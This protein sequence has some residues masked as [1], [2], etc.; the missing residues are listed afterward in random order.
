GD[1]LL[2]LMKDVPLAI[3]LDA[4]AQMYANG[5]AVTDFQ[6]PYSLK[7]LSG[8]SLSNSISYYFYAFLYERGEVGGVEDAFLYFNDLGGKPV[9]LLAGQFQVSDPMFKRE[10]RLEFEDYAVYRARMGDVPSDLT[11]DRGVLATA[12]L[13][14]FTLTGQI[15][16]GN[17]R[18]SADEE[19]RFD[20]DPGKTFVLHASRDLVE[21]FRLG[22]FV[23]SGR[24]ESED[25][26]N[27]TTMFG[28]DAT[29]SHGAFELNIQYLHRKDN[30]PTYDV[31]DPGASLDGGFAELLVRPAGS[32]WLGFALYNLIDAD[33]PIMDVRLGGPGPS[34]RYETLSGGLGYLLR[35]NL[36]L[37]GEA[38][39]DIELEASRWTFGF[40]SAF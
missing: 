8:G 24:T 7:I 29:L 30:R 2:S 9:D 31:L 37:T 28:G 1:E 4:Y 23:Y 3:R 13:A 20:S 11:Y 14:G 5:S 22:G 39:W 12:D 35:R 10:L 26:S 38:T 40:V 33:R 15:V 34:D 17:G 36:R 18:G 32:R 21:G 25:V 19:R 6:T 16:N 27:N